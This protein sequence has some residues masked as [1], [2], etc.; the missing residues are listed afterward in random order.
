MAISFDDHQLLTRSDPQIPQLKRYHYNLNGLQVQSYDTGL[1]V[2]YKRQWNAIQLKNLSE[3]MQ[4]AYQVKRSQKLTFERDAAYLQNALALF[5]GF[6]EEAGQ[7]YH[8]LPF[9]KKSP[10]ELQSLFSNQKL[11]A[12][13]AT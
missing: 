13:L 10:S 1:F 5:K 8:F 2:Y 7:P 11:S 3:G 9:C 12:Q 6:D 4:V